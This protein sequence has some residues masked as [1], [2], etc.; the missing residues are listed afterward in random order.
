VE[1]VVGQFMKRNGDKIFDFELQNYSKQEEIVKILK[2]KQE[3]IQILIDFQHY[4][5]YIK[6]TQMEIINI[7]CQDIEVED[8]K[9][10]TL[11]SQVFLQIQI[12]EKIT[13]SKESQK[14]E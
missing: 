7:L 13:E 3:N 14:N 12:L 10:Q 8:E 2:K 5:E 9:I 4:Y 1:S 6:K 11:E